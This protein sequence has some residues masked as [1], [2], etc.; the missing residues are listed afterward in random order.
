[1][2]TRPFGTLFLILGLPGLL[3]GCARSPA[4]AAGAEVPALWPVAER[5]SVATSPFGMRRHPNTGE[6]KMHKGI[7]IA[8]PMG[9]PVVATAGGVVRFSGKER[10]YGQM[11]VVDHGGG[12]ETAY[13]HLK[14]RKVAW[15]T[16]SA[17]AAW[18]GFSAGAATRPARICNMKCG[19]TAAP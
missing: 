13:G 1:M 8:A 9:T 3:A 16:G 12:I 11:V 6:Y 5:Q 4:Q 14:K 7:D 17:G 10:L 19:W 15:A 18:W 2:E